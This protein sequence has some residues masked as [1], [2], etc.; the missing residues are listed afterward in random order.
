[1][2]KNLI[3]G[4]PILLGVAFISTSI[5]TPVYASELSTD[6]N[7]TL[8][9]PSLESLLEQTWSN[10]TQTWKTI[11]DLPSTTT[12][13][14]VD[15]PTEDVKPIESE[16]VIKTVSDT[17]KTD[18]TQDNKV[19]SGNSTFDSNYPTFDN[20]KIIVKK[21]T[22]FDKVTLESPIEYTVQDGDTLE[23]L[24]YRFSIDPRYIIESNEG[25][26]YEKVHKDSPNFVNPWQVILIPNKTGIAYK[27][28][29][30]DT[31]VGIME[32]FNF[33]IKTWNKYNTIKN[34][35]PWD[36]I[37]F[38]ISNER[39]RFD[40]GS[41]SGSWTFYW[42]NCTW[43]VQQRL[44]WII[45][46]GG[47]ANTWLSTAKKKGYTVDN[48]PAKNSIVVMW[49]RGMPLGHVWVVESFSESSITLSEMNYSGL[50]KKTIRT[51]PRDHPSIQWYIHTS[52]SIY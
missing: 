20:K 14:N 35:V 19:E 24:W 32:K 6:S 23:S 45:D 21:V 4:V 29:P 15:T 42:W 46:W 27:V 38:P 17:D 12:I 11:D 40:N 41:N 31:K 44:N 7:T 22:N 5:L 18:K 13:L 39:L 52:K 50:W 36:I 34:P 9:P 3:K 28:K 26:I 1:M 48:T 47:N 37:V 49:G 10:N 30:G 43:Y 25:L 51:I 2:V 16:I 8:V 33:W